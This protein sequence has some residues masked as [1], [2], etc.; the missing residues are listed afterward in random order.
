V[1]HSSADSESAVIPPGTTKFSHEW[2][3]PN[4]MTATADRYSSSSTSLTGYV[5][6]R[7]VR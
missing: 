7:L 3:G 2:Y 1:A 5:E 6:Y 4:I